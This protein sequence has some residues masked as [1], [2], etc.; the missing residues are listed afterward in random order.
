MTNDDGFGDDEQAFRDA[1]SDVAP[2]QDK[3]KVQTR[4]GTG[5]ALSHATAE[6]RRRQAEG[7]DDPQ[8]ENPLTLGEVPPRGPHDVLAW[9]KDGVQLEVFAKLRSGGYPIERDLDLH[10]LTVAEAQVAVRRFVEKARD[11][12]VRSVRIAHG[13]GE[14]SA[15]PARLKSYLAHWLEHWDVVLAFHSAQRHHGGTGA[16]YCLLRKSDAKKAETR[17]RF[18]LQ[19]HD[20]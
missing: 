14:R 9:K 12:G 10:G 1:M 7:R 3:R 8:A 11:A 20:A 17:E 15:T 4:S 5:A 13:R 19:G 6:Q 18:G 2:L 16:V